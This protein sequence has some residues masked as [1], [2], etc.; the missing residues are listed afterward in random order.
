MPCLVLVGRLLFAAIFLAAAPRH[1]TSEGAAHAAELGVPLARIAVLRSGILAIA[2]GL[3][4]LIGYQTR[5][6]A[7]LLV[8]WSGRASR[9]ARRCRTAGPASAAGSREPGAAEMP[10]RA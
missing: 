6:S 8:A 3:G 5:V 4:V 9:R 2:G 10:G 7:W 1:F